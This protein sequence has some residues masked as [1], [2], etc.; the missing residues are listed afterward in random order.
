[1]R[2]QLILSTI[3]SAFSFFFSSHTAKAELKVCNGYD[4]EID[5][6]VGY[7]AKVNSSSQEIWWSEGWWS[8]EPGECRRLLNNDLN[9]KSYYLYANKDSIHDS[10]HNID[11]NTPFC[12]RRK[13]FTLPYL[14]HIGIDQCKPNHSKN[15]FKIKESGDKSKKLTY[16]L[17]NPESQNKNVCFPNEKNRIQSTN[18]K[19]SGTTCVGSTG[20]PLENLNYETPYYDSFIVLC[21]HLSTRNT[22]H[23]NI[24]LGK[25]K[26]SFKLE[27]DKCRTI[28]FLDKTG[29][30]YI[31]A[32]A[33]NQGITKTVSSWQYKSKIKKVIYKNTYK[34]IR[35]LSK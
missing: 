11:S 26:R 9:R 30:A 2:K 8:I 21:N 13:A 35:F 28:N 33:T 16:C 23:G 17:I 31:T 1:M 29:I 3:F 32:K 15:F 20:S 34:T 24:N 6:A 19:C 22:V 12:V 7:F 25:D 5:T 27:H 4:W 10:I 14:E 18:T